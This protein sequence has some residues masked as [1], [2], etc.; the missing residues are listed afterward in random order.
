M[1]DSRKKHR[2]LEHLSS[3]R[4]LSKIDK[5]REDCLSGVDDINPEIIK[6]LAKGATPALTE[7]GMSVKNVEDP[8]ERRTKISDCISKKANDFKESSDMT[9][10]EQQKFDEALE[11]LEKLIQE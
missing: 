4:I 3:L 8:Q 11:C 7:C 2:K 9:E 5:A 6:E 10:E 1:A